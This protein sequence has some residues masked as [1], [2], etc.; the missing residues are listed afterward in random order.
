MICQGGWGKI[1]SDQ[2][3]DS[4][5]GHIIAGSAQTVPRFCTGV[6]RF[7]V[8]AWRVKYGAFKR[9]MSFGKTLP[10]RFRRRESAEQ[11]L[12]R[13]GGIEHLH[14]VCENL[15]VEL[16]TSQF[17]SKRLMAPGYFQFRI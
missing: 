9:F 14:E 5:P 3:H 8:S 11:A 15:N 10:L 2:I 16:I 6:V 13:I 12:S 4:F 17:S 1:R 7:F